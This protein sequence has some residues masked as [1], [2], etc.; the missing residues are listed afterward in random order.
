MKELLIVVI[1]IIILL[2]LFLSSDIFVNDVV[3][4][5][6]TCCDQAN[7]TCYIRLG[8]VIIIQPNAYYSPS[9]CQPL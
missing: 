6:G 5:G 4:E 3:A 1:G 9:S 8:D 7:A 2:V